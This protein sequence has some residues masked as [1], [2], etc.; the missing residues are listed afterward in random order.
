M[1]VTEVTT[2]EVT[3]AANADVGWNNMTTVQMHGE[4]TENGF[5]LY[6]MHDFLF[7]FF[8][9]VLF[10]QVIGSPWLN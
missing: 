9:A 10:Y 1:I 3:G 7:L 8:L 6:S 4:V 5:D 2:R